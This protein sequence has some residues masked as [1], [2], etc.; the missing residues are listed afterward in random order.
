MYAGESRSPSAVPQ[1]PTDSGA[2]VE[3]IQLANGETIWYIVFVFFNTLVKFLAS[4]KS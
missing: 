3:V 2:G 1:E 4:G